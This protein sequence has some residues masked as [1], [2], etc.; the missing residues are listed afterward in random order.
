[1]NSS[2]YCH[3][4]FPTSANMMPMPLQQ[5]LSTS[6]IDTH[7]LAIIPWPYLFVHYPLFLNE[8][9]TNPKHLNR[10]A[11]IVFFAPIPSFCVST[12]CHSGFTRATNPT[13]EP[14]I[15]REIKALNDIIAQNVDDLEAQNGQMEVIIHQMSIVIE[16]LRNQYDQKSQTN[17]DWQMIIKEQVGKFFNCIVNVCKYFY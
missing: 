17:S 16:D 7:L 8:R 1:M 5:Q 14:Q 4:G 6:K 12:G 10:V 9:W 13:G 11:H 2:C 3:S 15:E